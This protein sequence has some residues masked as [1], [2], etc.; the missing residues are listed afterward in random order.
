[1]RAFADDM[2]SSGKPLDDE[3]LVSYILVGLDEEYNSVVTTLVA[4]SDTVSLA[5]AYAQLLHYKQWQ[6]LLHDESNEHHSTNL[7]NRGR[8]SQRGRGTQRGRMS[9]GSGRNSSGPPRHNGSN[10]SNDNQPRC[11]LCKKKGHMVMDCWHRFDEKFVPDN[12]FA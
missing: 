11:Q 9:R 6:N 4:R 8:G 10:S 1:M 7:A 3:D 12:R 5:E 2:A